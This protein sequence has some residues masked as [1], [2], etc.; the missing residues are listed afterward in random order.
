M[1]FR[2]HG[3]VVPYFTPIGVYD[4]IS[5]VITDTC[6]IEYSDINIRLNEDL[7]SADLMIRLE[8]GGIT[9]DV[10]PEFRLLDPHN[11]EVYKEAGNPREWLA[12]PDNKSE[13]SFKAAINS[14]LLW[15]PKNYGGQP[16]YTLEMILRSSDGKTEY[17]RETKTIGFRKVENVGDMKF[18]VN[19]KIVKLW[20]SCITP[21][22]GVSHRWQRERGYK[23]LDYAEKGN[24]NVM[25]LWGPSQPYHGEF[26]EQC[27]RLGILIWQE[28]HTWGTHMP[29]LE[30]YRDS[31]LKE[32]RGMIRRLKHHSC[33]FMWCGGNEQIYMAD[34][35]DSTA[36]ER[37]GHDI[38]YYDLKN[39][40]ASLDP[41]RYYH[42]SSPSMGQYANEAI[43]GDNHGSRASGSFLPGE[44]HSHFFSEDIRTSIPEL[45]SLV[46]FIKPGDL[47]PK[48]YKDTRPYGITKP[49]PDTWMNRTINRMEH[50]TGPY[51]LFYDATDP[52]SLVYKINA[53]ASYDNRL[54]INRLRQG[55]PFY[56]SMASRSCNGYLIWKL[57]TAWPQIYCALIDYYLEPGQ[58][59]YAT[60]RAYAPLHVSID[61][62]DHVYV[63]GTNDTIMN[64]TGTLCIEIFD[65]ESET[66]THRITYP[67]GIT[68]GDSVIIKNLDDIGQFKTTS[69]LH[70]V[71]IDPSGSFADE[72]FQY[73]Y[74]ERRLVFPEAK[75][76][77]EKTD[78]KSFRISTDRFARCVELS[79]DCDGNAFGWHFEDNYFDLMPGQ[80]RT[81]KWYGE[82][83]RGSIYAK[84]HYSPF[85]TTL[86]L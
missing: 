19:G 78:D 62:Q 41:Y 27:S 70:A 8:T 44:A 75:I 6:E 37:F 42:I 46:R 73:I 64:F 56:N 18:R 54:I 67:A 14:P 79:G 82:H 72:D 2:S 13:Y 77:L 7:S 35:F 83:I 85:K 61:L 59:Y 21:M 66:L 53:A 45:K 39:L 51:E 55:K 29:D 80:I 30:E 11:R 76:N 33:I 40:T 71:L 38:I 68:A 74:P 34:L 20:G 57:D 63:W 86:K 12:L 22:W 84:A 26:Y 17:D 65:L 4:D 52:E 32:A 31:V 50:K 60:R 43:F 28:F 1:L 15:W 47:W 23:L 16:L 69:V 25:R 49:L 81:I 24:M 58:T 9:G 10:I 36:K 48:G 3:G 5:L